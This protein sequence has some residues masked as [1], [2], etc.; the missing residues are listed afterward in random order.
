[1]SASMSGMVGLHSMDLGLA[2]SS[3][4]AYP[5]NNT[6]NTSNTNNTNTT[7][8]SSSNM[9]EVS[10]SVA[11]TSMYGLSQAAGAMSPLMEG[12][13][14]ELEEQS[15]QSIDASHDSASGGSGAARGGGGG[16]GNDGFVVGLHDSDMGDGGAGG[17]GG[18]GGDGGASSVRS[19]GSSSGGASPPPPPPEAQAFLEQYSDLLVDMVKKKLDEDKAA[20]Q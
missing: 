16:G 15:M 6:N 19:S 5:H 1:M 12:G 8:N 9:Q 13:T 4:A 18:G 7:D 14:M 10:S 20:T 2:S 17:N 11:S 3:S